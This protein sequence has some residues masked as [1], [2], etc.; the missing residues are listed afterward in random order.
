M[1]RCR[2]W[3]AEREV[4]VVFATPKKVWAPFLSK[5]IP[6]SSQ[7]NAHLC[8]HFFVHERVRSRERE[9]EGEY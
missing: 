9:R 4:A 2:C 6:W 1:Y 3:D 7:S 5:M 8:F